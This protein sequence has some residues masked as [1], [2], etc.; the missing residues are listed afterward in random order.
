[1]P[2]DGSGCGVALGGFSL[3]SGL[4]AGLG[5]AGVSV[6]RLRRRDR[7]VV[8]SVEFTRSRSLTS[9]LGAICWRLLLVRRVERS[10][11]L[12]VGLGRVVGTSICTGKG[13]PGLLLG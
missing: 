10:D 9:G 6:S 7:V 8:S 12:G 13:E 5:V 11:S 1:M 2:S 3:T 4:E